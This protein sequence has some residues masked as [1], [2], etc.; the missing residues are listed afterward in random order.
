[1]CHGRFKAWK[2]TAMSHPIVADTF[3]ELGFSDLVP[4]PT[5]LTARIHMHQ[6]SKDTPRYHGVFHGIW[7]GIRIWAYLGTLYLAWLTEQA[8]SLKL[9]KANSFEPVL[10]MIPK[11]SF[12]TIYIYMFTYLRSGLVGI[13]GAIFSSFH[14]LLRCIISDLILQERSFHQHPCYHIWIFRIDQSCG[15]FGSRLTDPHHFQ[16]GPGQFILASHE[17]RDWI[18]SLSE[19]QLGV[20]TEIRWGSERCTQPLR[21]PN[22]Q[23]PWADRRDWWRRRSVNHRGGFPGRSHG[24]AVPD[25]AR[26]W[27]HVKCGIIDQCLD[28]KGSSDATQLRVPRVALCQL[29]AGWDQSCLG[30]RG[31]IRHRVDMW[32]MGRGFSSSLI[33]SPSLPTFFMANAPWHLCILHG[34]QD[35]QWKRD[36]VSLGPEG[37]QIWHRSDSSDP[38]RGW[39]LCQGGQQGKATTVDRGGG[40]H[41]LAGL[42]SELWVRRSHICSGPQ[43]FCRCGRLCSLEIWAACV[44]QS[45]DRCRGQWR[46]QAGVPVSWCQQQN[47]SEVLTDIGPRHLAHGV[48]HLRSDIDQ[49]HQLGPREQGSGWRARADGTVCSTGRCSPRLVEVLDSSERGGSWISGRLCRGPWGGQFPR[50]GSFEAFGAS[51]GSGGSSGIGRDVPPG[52]EAGADRPTIIDGCPD[53]ANLVNLVFRAIYFSSSNYFTLSSKYEK[54]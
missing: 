4:N 10:L 9:R 35:L 2:D 11:L 54:K 24:V 47:G 41:W 16:L 53:P 27:N 49:D 13:S 42:S 12:Y 19:R 30:D 22:A 1:M 26:Q 44:L 34:H 36:L 25:M 15:H 14:P 52:L 37:I 31:G 32:S 5:S 21:D 29:H 43:R 33:S 51:S 38:V 50:P 40:L 46:W 39:I 23:V 45:I 6:G 48:A 20:W 3:R 7:G 17:P 18:Q 28:R 8:S